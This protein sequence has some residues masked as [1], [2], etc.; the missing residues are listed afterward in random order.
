M[1]L[2]PEG[3]S[4]EEVVAEV[5]LA[6]SGRGL[7]LSALD[8][9]LVSEWAAQGV[10]LEAVAR[11]IQRTAEKAEYDRRPGAAILRSLRACRREVEAEHKRLVRLTAGE[12]SATRSEKQR[13]ERARGRVRAAR[14]AASRAGARGGAGAGVGA[15]RRATSA[16]TRSR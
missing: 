4:Y 13:Q 6:V 11:G 3:A 2:L 15:G 10:P 16:G 8:G 5:F 7:M 12:G 14:R 9:A 1:S